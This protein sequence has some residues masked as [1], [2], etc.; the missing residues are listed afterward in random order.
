MNNLERRHGPTGKDQSSNVKYHFL[1][2]GGSSSGLHREIQGASTH[3]DLLTCCSKSQTLLMSCS[4][5]SYSSNTQQHKKRL[6]RKQRTSTFLSYLIKKCVYTH[7][8]L[9]FVLHCH[10]NIFSYTAQ[11]DYTVVTH[12]CLRK[13]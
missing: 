3:P 4:T 8:P 2:L 7:L 6:A 10:Q 11:H 5:P 9:P 13:F 1:N 12:C